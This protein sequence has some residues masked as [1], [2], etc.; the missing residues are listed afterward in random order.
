MNQYGHLFYLNILTALT[1][2]ISRYG[3]VSAKAPLGTGWGVKIKGVEVQWWSILSKY[4]MIEDGALS[5][6]ILRLIMLVV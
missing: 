5:Y 4:I 1:M 3:V 6:H 2:H